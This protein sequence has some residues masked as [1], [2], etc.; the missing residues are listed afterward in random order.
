M[1][2]DEV[3]TSEREALLA[4]GVGSWELGVGRWMLGVEMPPCLDAIAPAGG[5]SAV[6]SFVT[7]T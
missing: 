2:N 1:K 6:D 5:E 4:L 3:L 7:R